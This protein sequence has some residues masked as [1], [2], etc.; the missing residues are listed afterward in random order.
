[1]GL[2]R[3]LLGQGR[4]RS[5]GRE[6][7]TLTGVRVRSYAEKT[8]ADYLTGAGI[9]YQYEKP[10]KSRRF[11]SFK[12]IA[13]PDFYLPEYRVFV[14]YWGLVG[15]DDEGTRRSYRERMGYKMS[16]YRRH[17]IKVVSLYPADL[18]HLD[19]AFRTKLRELTS[20]ELPIT[21]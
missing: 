10:A 21:V 18:E 16:Q 17:N 13:R 1:M 7:V 4:N 12:Q 5:Y 8:V 9:E 3:S 14:E 6:S 11:L 15:A 19:S 20:R 2:L